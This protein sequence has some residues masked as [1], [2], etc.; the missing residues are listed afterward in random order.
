MMLPAPGREYLPRFVHPNPFLAALVLGVGGFI[1]AICLLYAGKSGPTG[2]E[3]HYLV[4]SETLLKYHSLDVA[5]TYHNRDYLSF[6]HGT[7]DLSHTVA[8]QDGR[9]VS[10]HGV[11]GPILWLPLFAVAG[12]MG[13]ILFMAGVSLLIIVGIFR[14]LEERGIRKTSAL[15]V[16]GLFA[17]STPFFAFSHLT[18]VDLIAALAVIHLFRKILKEGDL[19]KGELVTSSTLLGILPWVHVKFV[20]VEALLLLFLLA[21][22]VAA[23]KPMPVDAIVRSVLARWREV[24]WAVLPAVALGLGFEAFTHGTWNSFN[25]ALV[26]GTGDR[27]L[28]LTASPV[29]GFIGTF[30][31]QEYGIFISAPILMLA[32]PG[33]VL[34]VRDR[35]GALNVYS[36]ILAVCYL[37]LFVARD[38]WEGG[39]TPPGRFI[40]VLLPLFAYYVAHLLDRPNRFLAWPAFWI[41]GAVGTAYNLVSLQSPNHGF[42][43]GVG[44]NQTIMY[45]QQLVPHLSL[46]RYL[47]S[48]VKGMDY[49]LV[50]VWAF[51]VAAICGLVLLK[52]PLEERKVSSAA[53]DRGAFPQENS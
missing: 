28:P 23:N 40:L 3:P 20:V 12:R 8:N 35:V 26:Y 49:E 10:V 21:R 50:T 45:V 25:P 39:W 7:L 52:I 51:I 2:D 42:S 43:A 11:G 48:T 19:R 9:H 4:I 18:F 29:R 38:D 37:A 14:F 17:A 5:T 44:Q 22:I 13:A 15:A 32:I 46:T 31:D 41:L 53:D 6:Y 33:I 24:C 36:A 30:L 27:T 34:A 1:L 47:P 16:A